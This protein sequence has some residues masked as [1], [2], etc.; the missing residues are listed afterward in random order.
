[1]LTQVKELENSF[2]SKD[3]DLVSSIQKVELERVKFV[4]SSYLRERLK[5][6][7]NNVLH[8]LENESKSAKLSPAELKFAK[9]FAEN[10]QNHFNGLA[11]QHMPANMQTPDQ[12]KNIPRP[13]LDE[14]VFAKVNE[15]QEQVMIDP[16]EEPFDLEDNSQ[17][18]VRYNPIA[19]FIEN[20]TVSLM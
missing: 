15:K 18:I 5:K 17:H 20:G 13:N 12:K 16:E 9:S 2:T 3:K 1:M 4:I 8:I 6:I 19:A 14:Y 7:E 10:L 11:L